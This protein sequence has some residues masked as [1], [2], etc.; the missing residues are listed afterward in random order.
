MPAI[1]TIAAEGP[2]PQGAPFAALYRE[3]FDAVCGWARLLGAVPPVDQDVAQEV[4]VVAYRKLSTL[5]G[6]ARARSWLFGITRRVARDFR[7]AKNRRD[8]RHRHAEGPRPLPDPHDLT[9]RREATRM[10]EAFVAQLDERKRLIF[11]LSEIDQ[12]SAPEVAEALGVP[13]RTVRSRL[14]VARERFRAIAEAYQRQKGG[15]GHD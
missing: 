15:S 7:R 2:A 14:R 11:V 8:V 6:E 9:T 4:F 12:M 5:D 3:N 1:G 10:V 13:V